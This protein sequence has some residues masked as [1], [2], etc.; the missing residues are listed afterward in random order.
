MTRHYLVLPRK[1]QAEAVSEGLEDR[2]KSALG[3]LD[4][5]SSELRASRD[6]VVTL[7]KRLG[8]AATREEGCVLG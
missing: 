6:E 7:K 5:A 1:S 8:E 3:N 4:Q 2:L